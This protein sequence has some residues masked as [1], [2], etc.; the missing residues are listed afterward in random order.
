MRERWPSTVL[1]ETNSRAAT[2]LV[3]S[4]SATSS[5]TRCSVGVRAPVAGGRPPTA[6]S[7]VAGAVRPHAR[8]DGVEAG[9]GG[10]ERRAGVGLAPR[11]AQR[12]AVGEAGWPA[13]PGS[14]PRRGA[15]PRSA[16][17]RGARR[18]RRARRPAAR[19]QRAAAASADVRPSRRALP[20]S[21]PSS[22]SAGRARAKAI[23]AS[24]WSGTTRAAPGSAICSAR[25]NP[26]SGPSAC[27]ASA[28]LPAD[29]SSRPSA[30]RAKCSA[31]RPFVRTAAASA[32]PARSRP[33]S[34]SPAI[35]SASARSASRYAPTVAWPVCSASARPSS[36]VTP[37]A[38]HIP[39]HAGDLGA[40][41]EDVGERGLV[42]DLG[43]LAR[44][45]SRTP[46]ARARPRPT[47]AR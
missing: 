42:A 20:S 40:H 24:T 9:R 17:A 3:C 13:R 18:R 14:A 21:Q 23:S 34:S 19:G 43:G 44:A 31:G 10:F 8:A 47:T 12:G 45:G 11:A 2:C 39:A 7:S 28:G 27:T 26:T 22:S 35:A 33:S 29:C 15:R 46:R 38:G 41:H 30:A 4:P 25:R 1:G 5:A 36:V 32:R 37:R 16:G 6:A